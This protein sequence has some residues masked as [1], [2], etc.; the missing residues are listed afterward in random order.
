MQ[1][2]GKQVQCMQITRVH[3]WLVSRAADACADCADSGCS[4]FAALL[5]ADSANKP[6]IYHKCI[7]PSVCPVRAGF[8]L[9]VYQ[10][11][12]DHQHQQVL[13]LWLPHECLQ[14]ASHTVYQ[15]VPPCE[16]LD[17]L[18]TCKCPTVYCV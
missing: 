17:H 16:L 3:D 14:P 13:Y 12:V 5:H 1:S 8:W 11:E 7:T 2:P 10:L 6:F 9:K 4:W 18:G 15:P